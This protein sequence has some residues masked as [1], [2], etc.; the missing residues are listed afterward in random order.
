MLV[1]GYFANRGYFGPLARALDARGVAPIFAPDFSGTFAPIERFAGELHR[2][3]ERI[4]EGTGQSKV[5]LVCHSM[6][7]L[8]ARS[9]VAT[10]GAGRVARLI[11]IGSP[12]HGT[13]HARLGAGVNARQ[14]QRGSAFLAELERREA[15]GGDR[16][17]ATS[18]YLPHDD[19]VAPQDS[20]RLDWA[21]NLALP[22]YGHIE[23]VEAPRLVEV[24]VDELREAGVEA[25]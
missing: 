12:H 23:I 4:A 24:L 9:Y 1:H 18:I 8:A 6:G 16:P 15:E 14:M 25:R 20:S 22:G 3:I 10:H 19:L 7:G 5:V 2:E 13:V 17:Q 21:R 11:T